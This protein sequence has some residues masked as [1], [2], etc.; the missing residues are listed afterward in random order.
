M[1]YVCE[2][3]TEYTLEVGPVYKWTRQGSLPDALKGG[4]TSKREAEWAFKMYNASLKFVADKSIKENLEELNT[5]QELLS[6]AE[7]KGIEVP[8]K[9][10]A[11]SAIKKF[12]LGGYN[13]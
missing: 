7:N 5:K 11:P 6:Y 3:G 12:L 1:K 2:K 4:F 13:D 10:K 9:H 8:S